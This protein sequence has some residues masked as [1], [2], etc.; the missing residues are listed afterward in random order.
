MPILR[1]KYQ[2]RYLNEL[3]QISFLEGGYLMK[4]YIIKR[5]LSIIPILFII[6]I[7]VFSL[8]HLTPGDPAAAMLGAE[9]TQED[10]A[11]LRES[12]GLNEPLVKQYV[13]WIGNVFKGDL[14]VSVA[15]S[16]P[17]TKVLASRILPTINL[18]VYAM[19]I[20]LVIA[21]PL[22]M[23]AARKRGTF[24]DQIISVFALCGISVPSFLLGLA[25]MMG[26]AVKLRWFPVSG[27]VPWAG[28]ALAHIKSLTLPAIA[29][30]F[31]Y[32]AL[33][34]RMTRASMLEVL[35]SD[36]IKMAK[37]KGV[38]EASLVGK[39]AFRNALVS[40]VTVIG[41]SFIGALS[42]AAVVENVFGIPGIGSLIVT[43]IGRRDYEVI[44]GI[45]LL[46]AIINVV[47]N[48][49]TDLVYGVIDPR[50]RVN[51]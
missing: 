9:A 30:G 36:Y 22:G 8:I 31:M 14:G 28:G 17:V 47:I 39:H 2:R 26:F 12:L 33:M 4:N 11:I 43:S 7:I 45:V 48:L 50:I 41:A 27:Y 46:V 38:R 32:A 15:N 13:V 18:A 35:N 10:I 3:I 37:A 6:S 29:L 34:L 42:G 5:I 24:I 21:L 49:L 16:E 25:L 1:N 23:I 51:S 40:V 20:S 19:L 44:Q